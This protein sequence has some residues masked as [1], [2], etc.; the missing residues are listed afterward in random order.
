MWI[1]YSPKDEIMRILEESELI[2]TVPNVKVINISQRS[3]GSL[4][5]VSFRESESSPRTL[6][7]TN[8]VMGFHC[9][10]PVKEVISPVT[11]RRVAVF[12]T[13]LSPATAE[14]YETRQPRIRPI[15]LV[16]IKK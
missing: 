1:G 3:P 13:L 11:F 14:I 4:Y 8:R 7:E 10:V 16:M 12:I 15:K 2:E 9:M 6:Y 5:N